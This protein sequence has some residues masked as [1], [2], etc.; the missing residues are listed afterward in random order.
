MTPILDIADMGVF[1]G[2]HQMLHWN[3]DMFM[4]QCTCLLWL[5]TFLVNKTTMYGMSLKDHTF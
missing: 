3:K 2:V 4:C 1:C 5:F